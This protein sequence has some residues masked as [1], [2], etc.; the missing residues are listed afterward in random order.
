M[1]PPEKVLTASSLKKFKRKKAS[2]GPYDF[3]SKALK[4]KG[5]NA[6]FWKNNMQAVAQVKNRIPS[7]WTRALIVVGV[8]EKS[9]Q[10]VFSLATKEREFYTNAD[11]EVFLQEETMRWEPDLSIINEK[12]FYVKYVGLSNRKTLLW[13]DIAGTTYVYSRQ[14]GNDSIKEI[15]RKFQKML[16]YG[17]SGGRALAW[18]KKNTEYTGTKLPTDQAKSKVEG[19]TA[20]QLI[21]AYLKAS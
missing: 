12:P 11:V 14:P 1:L 3:Q 5:P 20:E 16:S 9:A 17:K 4:G 18:L 6:L 19:I 15:A 7:N 21:D 8:D 2:I 13:V 10:K